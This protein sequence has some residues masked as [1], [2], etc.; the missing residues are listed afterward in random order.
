MLRNLLLV[1]TGLF[2]LPA[3]ATHIVGGELYYT[4][5]GNNSYLVTLKVYRDCGP[6]NGNGTGFDNIASVGIFQANGTLLTSIGMDLFN[7]EVNL[8]PV[9]LENPCF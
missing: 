1:L 8:I 5:Q 2:S 9:E 6:S 7:A 3:L 4:W